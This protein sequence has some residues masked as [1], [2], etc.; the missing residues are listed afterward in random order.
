VVYSGLLA[1]LKEANEKLK[2]GGPAV[3]GD[4]LYNGDILKWKKFANSLRVRLANRQ[5]AKKSAES[6]AVL[7]EILGNASTY[8][9]FTS[10]DDNAVLKN[11]DSRPSNNEF[12]EVMIVG[13][14]TD[15]NLSKTIVD[16]L[17]ALKDTRLAVFG[18]PVKGIYEGIPNGLPDAIATT[19]LSSAATLGNYFTKASA[20]SVLMTFSEL[21]LDLAEAAIDGDITGSADEYFKKGINASF[22]Q[23]GATIPADYF[24]TVGTVSKEKI[25]DQKWIALFG[26]GVEA[27]TEYR[28]TGYPVLPAK[29]PR[30]VFENNG[31]IPTRLPY[32]TTEY[33]L[34]KTKLDA[35]ISLI[36][37]DDMQA[38]LWW[39]EK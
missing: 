1:D 37:K 36:G 24:T 22:T 2:V 23:F 10:N 27:W 17:L 19:Y 15:W 30:A 8:P 18:T 39:S 20:P 33:S 13:G 29:D 31:I 9:I 34:N 25:L 5:A 38:K 26:Q 6:K 28:R 32:P 14:R 12:N 16:K 11:T 21:Q 35:G 3:S 4:I 7:A